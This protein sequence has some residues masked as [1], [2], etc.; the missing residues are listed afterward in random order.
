MN[1]QKMREEFEEWCALKNDCDYREGAWDA[2]QASC[3]T[4]RGRGDQLCDCLEA[5]LEGLSNCSHG[6]PVCAYGDNEA[7][8]YMANRADAM[9]K[10]GYPKKRNLF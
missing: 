6:I 1:E 3:A 4:V 9:I 10:N 7:A 2:W 5:I 8:C